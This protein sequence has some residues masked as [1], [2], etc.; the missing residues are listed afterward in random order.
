MKIFRQIVQVWYFFAH[1]KREW[2]SVVP[3]TIFGGRLAL[4]IQIDGSGNFG[5]FDES[6]KKGNTSK[7]LPFSP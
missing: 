6:G 2:D 1:R 7:V 4:I 5:L 3:F